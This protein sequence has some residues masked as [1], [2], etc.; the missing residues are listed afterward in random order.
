M[1]NF[2]QILSYWKSDDKKAKNSINLSLFQ[3]KFY[4]HKCRVKK[5]KTL[6]F[7]GFMIEMFQFYEY[8]KK[9]ST[10]KACSTGTI[11]AFLLD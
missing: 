6:K 5:K 10:S 4:I 2:K 7:T 11:C 3:S 9:M 8:D 1:R